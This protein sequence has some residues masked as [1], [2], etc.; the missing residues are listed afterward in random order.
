[1]RCRLRDGAPVSLDFP[2]PSGPIEAAA[3]VVGFIA[4]GRVL[5]LHATS[6][7]G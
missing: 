5:G 1:M 7:R 3:V 2:R 4:L 6:M